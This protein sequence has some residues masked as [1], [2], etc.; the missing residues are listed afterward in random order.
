[1]RVAI[2]HDALI[3]TGGAERVVQY[4]HEAFPDA[5]I[6]TSAY[7][8]SQTYPAFR[9]LDVRPMRH[10][11]IAK[12]EMQAKAL[13][14]L[15]V[16]GFSRIDFSRYDIVLTSS[17]YAAKAILANPP[18]QHICYCYAPFRLA[19]DW[20]SYREQLS[21]PR[22]V[23]ALVPLV[24]VVLRYW[25]YG[26]SQRVHHFITSSKAV[27]R[28]IEA[29][30]RRSA[31]VINPPIPIAHYPIGEAGGEHYLV[32]SRLN[33]YKRVDLAISAFN[34]LKRNL[35][36]VGDGPE[37]ERLEQMA[38]DNIQFAGRVS[39]EQLC[40][41]YRDCRALIFPGEE[42]Y[43]LV[44]LEAQACGKPVVA[45]RAGGVLETVEEGVGGVFFDRQAPEALIEAVAKLESFTFDPAD[46]R[47]HASKFDVGTFVDRLRDVVNEVYLLS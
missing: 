1:M 20:P 6:Y 35:V 45:Y 4:M 36:I 3:N 38:N 39:D 26:V 19:W 44:P 10:L 40:K 32:V 37:R 30:Y 8:P 2:V 42:D 33:R 7:F 47:R 21:L 41:C 16:W 22:A 17:S 34:H 28:R 5:P 9:N 13:M 11:R 14:P 23:R 15:M 43:G 12:T 29:C 25:D 24:S 27:A 31:I 18:T 46:I